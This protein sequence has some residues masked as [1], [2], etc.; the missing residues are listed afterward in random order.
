MI[1]RTIIAA[2]LGVVVASPAVLAQDMR[3][4]ARPAADRNV[5]QQATEVQRQSEQ[6]RLDDY[7]AKHNDN[8]PAYP[9]NP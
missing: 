4:P 2:L 3:S 9:F 1:K 5:Q 6:Q 7:W 8:A